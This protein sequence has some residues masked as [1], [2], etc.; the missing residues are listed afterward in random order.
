MC[1]YI[2]IY[3]YIYIYNRASRCGPKLELATIR[4]GGPM[5][6]FGGPIVVACAVANLKLRGAVRGPLWR[7]MRGFWESFW[8]P[9]SSLKAVSVHLRFLKDV[10]NEMLTFG[11]PELSRE[12]LNWVLASSFGMF[13]CFCISTPPCGGQV[14]PSWPFWGLPGT[15][16]AGFR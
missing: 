3:I 2:Y 16:Q 12:S 1:K 7:P 13:V 11:N 5:L 8:R 15:P 6:I 14:K 10:L 9:S 4:H